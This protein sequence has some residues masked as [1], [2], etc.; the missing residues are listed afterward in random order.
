MLKRMQP[1]ACHALDVPLFSRRRKN[2]PQPAV[3]DGGPTFEEPN[4]AERDW[5]AGH[6]KFTT[7]MRIDLNDADA[8]ARLYDSLLSNW[9]DAPADRRE[10][11]NV[12]INI[13]GTA[14]GEHLVRRTPMRWVVVSDSLGTELAVHDLATDLLVYPANAV[15][16][17]WTSAD[18]GTFVSFMSDDIARRTNA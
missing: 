10:D 16:K 15:A 4:Q 8:V 9:S 12:L 17:R 13:L 5:M 6:L 3:S 14:F 11:P 1:V 2:D 7:D 18:P